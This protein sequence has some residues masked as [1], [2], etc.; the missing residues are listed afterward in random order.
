MSQPAGAAASAHSDQIALVLAQLEGDVPSLCAAACVAR[1][2]RVAAAVPALWARLARLPP[3][4]AQRLND[5]RLGALVARA[6]GGLQHLDVSGAVHLSND[7]L[8][9]ALRQPHALTRFEA[10]FACSL[11]VDRVAAALASRTGHLVRLSVTGLAIGPVAPVLERRWYRTERSQPEL[12]AFYQQAR[13][14]QAALHALLAPDGVLIG[15][16]CCEG[17]DGQPCAV[18]CAPSDACGNCGNALCEDH[19]EEMFVECTGCGLPFCN[20]HCICDDTCES[21]LEDAGNEA[22]R[23]DPS[24]C[25]EE[26]WSD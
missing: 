1:A 18:L 6:A 15:E 11:T 7:G 13:A 10:E 21:C 3:A 9:T 22:L 12:R 2:W 23:C 25:W 20:D 17:V 14:V 8:E 5:D 24:I 19:A 26:Y 16:D 4:A